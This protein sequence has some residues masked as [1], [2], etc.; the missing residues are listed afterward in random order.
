[1]SD[2]YTPLTYENFNGL[3]TQDPAISVPKTMLAA[4]SAFLIRS[5]MLMSQPSFKTKYNGSTL[6]GAPDGLEFNA[7]TTFLDSN[8][9]AHTIGLTSGNCYQLTSSLTWSLIGTIATNITA[10]YAVQAFVNKLYFSNGNTLYFI[11]GLGTTVVQTATSVCGGLYITSLANSLILAYTLEGSAIYPQRVRWSAPNQPTEWDPTSNVGAGFNTLQDLADGIS[12]LA[13][14]GTNAYIFSPNNITVMSPTGNNQLPF[15][16]DHLWFSP[17]G[18]GCAFPQSLS[19]YGGTVGFVSTENIY[20]LKLNG[21]Q[22]IGDKIIDSFFNYIFNFSDFTTSQTL[23]FGQFFPGFVT[24]GVI[25]SNLMYNIYVTHVGSGQSVT[26]VYSYNVNYGGW[27][28]Y[29]AANLSLTCKPAIVS[30]G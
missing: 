4:G 22:G 3:D 15:T 14:I 27:S 30:I 13:N 26:R 19:S 17:K 16:F 29:E 5:G 28:I 10:P 20:L 21:I 18:V 12:G 9:V 23:V 6:P 11:D 24:N 1:M 7:I 25:T 8:N 2:K